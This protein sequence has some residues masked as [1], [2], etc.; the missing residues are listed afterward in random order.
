MNKPKITFGKIQLNIKKDE[1]V[2]SSKKAEEKVET[3][4]TSGERLTIS[5]YFYHTIKTF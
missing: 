3:I 2:E 1:P 4:P 5:F